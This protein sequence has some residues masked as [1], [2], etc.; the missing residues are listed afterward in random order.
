MLR[1]GTIISLAF[2]LSWSAC[3]DSGSVCGN[4]KKESGEQCDCG[5]DPN[6]IPENCRAINGAPRS[7]CSDT[8]GLLAAHYTSLIVVW[9]INGSPGG[10]ATFDT[11]NDAHADQVQVHVTGPSGF[12][13]SQ[14]TGCAQYQVSFLETNQNPL[15]AGTYTIDAT[16]LSAGKPITK[17]VT[18]QGMV[19]LDQTN[20]I[21]VDF[22]LDSFLDKDSLRG[23]LMLDLDWAGQGCAD[24]SPVVTT[25][26]TFVWMDEQLLDGF[27]ARRGCVDDLWRFSDLPVADMAIEVQGLDASD[28]VLY[29]LE[30]PIKVGIGGNI[31][32]TLSIPTHD[33]S[34]ATPCRQ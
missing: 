10:T 17:P 19:Q 29:C 14:T 4:G 7:T 32:F 16:L 30:Q 15:Q 18:G 12:S 3:S 20:T 31:P 33:A 22:D 21:V 34:D 2:L 8:C 23:T 25:Q 5:K 11:C 27:P 13:N 26:Q 1:F 6:N 28:Q 24:A 9:T